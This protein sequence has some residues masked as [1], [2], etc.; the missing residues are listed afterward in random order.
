MLRPRSAS[1]A[2]AAVLAALIPCLFTAC[3]YYWTEGG[4]G[5][6][7]ARAIVGVLGLAALGACAAVLAGRDLPAWSWRAP[8]PWFLLALGWQ[9]LALAL[10][11]PLP[12][13]GGLIVAE[14]CAALA[15]AVAVAAWRPSWWALALW[16]LA[17]LGGDVIS[18]HLVGEGWI[19]KVVANWGPAAPFGNQNFNA[20]AAPLAVLGVGLAW[21]AVRTARHAGAGT[22]IAAGLGLTALACGVVMA[23]PDS[24]GGRGTQ[25]IVLAMTA[26]L[27][28]WL[29]LALPLPR[30]IGPAV[31]AAGFSLLLAV[32]AAFIAGWMPV[33][34]KP[35]WEQRVWFW[36]GSLR[37]IGESPIIGIGPGGTLDALQRVPEACGHWLAVPSFAEHAHNEWLQ[38]FLDG[39]V[40]N[41]ALVATGLALTLLPLWR[42]RR[43]PAAR[44]LLAAWAALLAHALAESHLSQPGAVW[45]AALLAGASWGWI[46]ATT[47]ASVREADAPGF[48]AQ[49]GT[50]GL[51]LLAA[52]LMGWMA[53]RDFGPGGSPPMLWRRYFTDADRFEAASRWREAAASLAALRA[54][55]GPL[56][57]LLWREARLRLL[58]CKELPAAMAAAE[59]AEAERLVTEQLR[60]LPVAAGGLRLGRHLAEERRRLGRPPGDLESALVAAEPAARLWLER[61][62]D[63]G[64]NTAHRKALAAALDEPKKTSPEK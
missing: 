2:A 36:R 16:A 27:G 62:H 63:N 40:V 18:L 25:A 64:K 53:V 35:S 19:G 56:D 60:R 21:P 47:T 5:I 7:P 15:V 57:D 61:S 1:P 51:G 32:Q 28:T 45:C 24:W 30:L 46:R 14:R 42:R 49:V 52:G 31:V 17:I 13:P 33:P 43:S 54:R 3:W 4:T 10:W 39:G 41:A 6:M 29:M 37:A 50:V 23:L 11:S 22:W 12:D 38:V 34:A 58:S 9:A 20:A 44:A 26:G 55:N 59:Q 48:P 8:L